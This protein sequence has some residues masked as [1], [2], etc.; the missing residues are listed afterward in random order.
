MS[1]REIC[2]IP[3]V[4][5]VGRPNVGKSSLFNLMVGRRKA[6]VHE[7][8]GVT[9][10]RIISMAAFKGRIFQVADTGGLGVFSSETKRLGQWDAGI[11]AQVETALESADMIVF[12]TEASAGMTPLDNDI[13]RHLMTSGKPCYVAS[14]KSDTPALDLMAQDF[15]ACGAEAIFPIS[16]LHRRGIG[17]LLS[18]MVTR[19]EAPRAGDECS[20]P[21][22]IA[23]VG[24]PN[25]GKS[26]LV[27][28]LLG[29]DRMMVSD[30]PGTTRDAV[31]ARFDLEFRGERISAV[32]V[33]T[34]GLRKKGRADSAVEIF[35]IMRSESAVKRSDIVL[36]VLDASEG[37][38][39][40]QDKKI[41]SMVEA[42]GKG[43]II[44][45]NKFDLCHGADKITLIEA[46]RNSLKFLRYTPII[47]SSAVGDRH[48]DK[49]SE[50]IAILKNQMNLKVP[51]PVL[52]KLLSDVCGRTPPPPSTGGR[53]L[54]IYYGTMTDSTPPHFI[55]FVNDPK[56]CTQSYMQYIKNSLHDSLGITGWPVT[57]SLKRREK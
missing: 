9:R 32:L 6:I 55:L 1:G 15:A 11:R 27:N 20:T 30:I 31:D 21:L 42:S 53:S 3:T 40:A 44:V 23:V 22:N 43:C 14:N 39:T 25:V 26:S 49:L 24:R 38:V 8:S 50:Q 51:T 54:K 7:E 10:D 37:K 41:A 33:D 56:L 48:F 17:E 12:V 5:I 47:L 13:A 34:A 28:R 46:L 16:C 29:E 19:I 52:N 45:A 35:S 18:A 2:K 4:V 57:L 36:L